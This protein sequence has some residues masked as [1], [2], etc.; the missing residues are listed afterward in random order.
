MD[1]LLVALDVDRATEAERLTQEL[2]GVAGGF[3]IGSRLFTAEGP[4]FV[5]RLTER[6]VRVFL[7]LKFHDIPNTVAEAVT[8][9]TR[10]GVWMMTIH[11]SGG[12]A[13]MQAAAHAARDTA[14]LI[15]VPPPHVVGVTV[16]TSLD[17]TTLRDLGISRD[18]PTH[19]EAM[20][21]LARDAKQM[22]EPSGAVALAGLVQM[23]AQAER[24]SADVGVIVSGGNV[25]LDR[26]SSLV[27][28]GG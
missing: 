16:L 4:Q 24:V 6:G 3:K 11:T 17:A 22:V 19:V 26:W 14:S 21:R 27:T 25:D 1:Q 28:S 13:M 12:A 2:A 18:V 15:G 9:A 7:D 10:L 23:V 20:A 8:E 5:R